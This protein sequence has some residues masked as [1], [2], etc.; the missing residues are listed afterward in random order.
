MKI[1]QCNGKTYNVLIDSS[2]YPKK[3]FLTQDL[4]FLKYDYDKSIENNKLPLVEFNRDQIKIKFVG[5]LI[6]PNSNY[7]S[8]PKNF[9]SSVN[10]I[11]IVLEVLSRYKDLKKDGKTLMSN[12]SFSSS[13]S[14]I[15]SN[16]FYFDKLKEFF[17]DY[18][19]YEFIFPKKR[20]EIHSSRPIK[21][22]KIDVK[23]TEMQVDRLG[24]G[25][26]YRVKDIK[27]SKSWNLDDIYFTT[28]INLMNEYGNDSDRNK[29][30]NMTS[31]LRDE[32]YDFN[33]VD[34]DYSSVLKDIN[35]CEVDI[36][37]Y[38]I[39]NTLLSYYR[40]RKI[41]ERYDIRAFYTKNFEYVW[42]FFSRKVFHDNIEFRKESRIEKMINITHKDIVEEIDDIRP[43]V[44]SEYK[45]KRFI[46]DCKY[47][48]RLDSD[49]YKEMYQY[50]TAFGNQYPMVIFI[51]STKTQR[52][53][54]RRMQNFELFIIK[55]SLEEVVKDV[56]DNTNNTIDKIHLY[57]SN[58]ERWVDL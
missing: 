11:Q 52:H 19:T 27:N 9:T 24:P 14:G 33:L 48:R 8:L 22:S 32:G 50:N 20:I 17:L 7:I 34:I 44:F 46:G 29:I 42:E 25:I 39:K 49:F 51:P 1:L 5:E 37:H 57:L 16:I 28:I 35:S 6:T 40:D 58:S 12:K 47:Y 4:V 53:L 30:S 38:P 36:L 15:E 10:N 41:S 26:T 54:I 23:R 45:G 18:I 56:I 31:F 21:N 2:E 13:I 3:N 55:V 43:D